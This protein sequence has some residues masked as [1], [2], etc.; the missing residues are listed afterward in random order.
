MLQNIGAA[1]RVE[2]S[3]SLNV[4]TVHGANVSKTVS[5]HN[6]KVEDVVGQ[7]G[8][9]KASFEHKK[10]ITQSQKGLIDTSN[11]KGKAENPRVNNMELNCPLAGLFTFAVQVMSKTTSEHQWDAGCKV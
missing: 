5:N 1:G 3:D 8:A 2:G 11:S 6:N 9:E 10:V 4:G 7:E